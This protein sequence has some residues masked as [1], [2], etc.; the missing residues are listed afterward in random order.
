MKPVI[1]F[2]SFGVA[3]KDARER[4]LGS[5]VLD[6]RAKFKD[7]DVIEAYTSVFL[8]KKIAKDEGVTIPSL[9]EALEKLAQD[10]CPRV[11]ILPSHLTPGE[12]YEKKVRAAYEAYKGRIARL[13]LADP[14]FAGPADDQ[15]V[16]TALL[17]DLHVRPREE[18]VLMGHGSPHQHNPVYDRLQ[19]YVD[20]EDLPVH[21]GVIEPTDRPSFDD[22]LER[23]GKTG[24]KDVLLAPLLLTGGTHV[25]EDMAGDGPDSWKSRLEA[26]GYNVRVSLY[27]LGEYPAFRALYLD[28]AEAAM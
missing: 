23:L 1:I 14:V 25:Q 18:L 3:D 28:K 19:Q 20:C 21:I 4:T 7:W 13:A 12:E 5:V 27:G 2:T 16:L 24:H 26:A 10:G 17:L 22:V 15:R 11:L 9:E 6:L 8:R